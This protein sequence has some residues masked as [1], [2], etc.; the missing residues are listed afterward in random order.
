MDFIAV[1]GKS[2]IFAIDKKIRAALFQGR[3]GNF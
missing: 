1:K 2:T 3:C